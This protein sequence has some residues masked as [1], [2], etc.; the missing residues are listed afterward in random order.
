MAVKSWSLKL[1]FKFISII[2]M[3]FRDLKQLLTTLLLHVNIKKSKLPAHINSE[4]LYM[5]RMV[6][7]VMT[8]LRKCMLFL[9]LMGDQMCRSDHVES[10]RD[11]SAV[12][13][14]KRVSRIGASLT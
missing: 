8:V 2:F 1:Q 14:V 6:K 12:D 9:L 4:G 3:D 7:L 11:Y 10:C 5:P 13:C